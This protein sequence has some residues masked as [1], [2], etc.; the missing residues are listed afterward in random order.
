M[1]YS[2]DISATDTYQDLQETK[3]ELKKMI[4]KL[5]NLNRKLAKAEREYRI[6]Y[7]KK[8]VEMHINGL[9]T[10]EG[11]TDEVAW[12]TTPRLVKGVEEVAEKKYKVDIL[13]GDKD[14]VMQRIY[15]LKKD[16]DLLQKE[17][18]AIQKGE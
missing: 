13:E 9:E 8:C 6:E 5:P 2:T 1:A 12:S 11:R 16:I 10:E 7:T 14:A 15:K 18:E 4:N 17:L 3:S